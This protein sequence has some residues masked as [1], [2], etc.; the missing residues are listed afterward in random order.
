[1]NR[2]NPNPGKQRNETVGRAHKERKRCEE[3]TNGAMSAQR[4]G[5]MN[6]QRNGAMNAQRNGA[7]AQPIR[8]A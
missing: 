2:E 5:A 6:A 4:N 8:N 3:R 1:M 7:R